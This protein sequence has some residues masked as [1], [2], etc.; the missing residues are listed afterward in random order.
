MG[1]TQLPDSIPPGSTV[2]DIS[3]N[4]PLAP[5][6]TVI[7]VSTVPVAPGSA[8]DSATSSG[9]SSDGSD[10]SSS[11]SS[12]SSGA[13]AAPMPGEPKEAVSHPQGTTTVKVT[14]PG[15]QGS[16]NTITNS[17]DPQQVTI[18]SIMPAGNSLAVSNPAG[19]AAIWRSNPGSRAGFS[20]PGADSSQ[21]QGATQQQGGQ[22]ILPPLPTDGVDGEAD[23]EPAAA[24]QAQAGQ[25]QAGQQA[26]L[27][28]DLFMSGADQTEAPV[29]ETLKPVFGGT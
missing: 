28:P 26:G 20:G 14:G 15:Q 5:G 21:Q 27:S 24:G 19:P 23:G 4:N 7:D 17:K 1:A 25:G 2:I 12:G 10:G 11:I 16:V 18:I 9:S 22:Q 8:T 3:N 29:P 13:V 6:G